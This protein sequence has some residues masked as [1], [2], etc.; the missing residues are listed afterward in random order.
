MSHETE[1]WQYGPFSDRAKHHAFDF[2]QERR[3]FPYAVPQINRRPVV[4]ETDSDEEEWRHGPFSEKA[5][6]HVF[7]RYPNAGANLYP[8]TQKRPLVEYC[9]NEWRDNGRDR[10]PSHEYDLPGDRID[11]FWTFCYYCV[12]SRKIRRWT[13]FSMIILASALYIHI[14]II[15]PII[16]ENAL[17][18]KSL[19]LR[20]QLAKGKILGGV[21]GTN[22]RPFFQDMV[23][24]DQLDQNHLP[25]PRASRHSNPA[26]GQR[27]IFV[28]DIHGCNKELKALMEKLHFDPAKD[29]L[30]TTGDMIA[31]GPHSLDVVDYLRSINAS[32]VRGNHEDWIL[33]LAHD[34]NSTLLHETGSGRHVAAEEDKTDK[35]SVAEDIARSLSAEQIQYLEACPVILRIGRVAAFDSEVVVVHAGLVPGLPLESQEPSS[36]MN[37]RTIDLHSHVPSKD[38]KEGPGSDGNKS[39]NKNPLLLKTWPYNVHWTKLWNRWQKTDGRVVRG[40]EIVDLGLGHMTV[41]Y[42][43]DSRRGVE[44]ENWTQGIDGAC[45]SGGKLTALVV[46]EGAVSYT[47]QV[48]CEDYRPR[49][50]MELEEVLREEGGV[51]QGRVEWGD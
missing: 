4:Q 30:V 33:L 47:E 24:I 39:P 5:E 6:H 36:V 48:R 10:S 9:T 27:L 29:H 40:K 38:G 34:M 35:E 22:T 2:Y 46:G 41:V 42:G 18:T 13:L 25:D 15:S 8:P 37:M 17:L 26:D 50:R 7:D 3:I 43:H 16:V 14:N 23:Y 20:E 49:K 32:C 12:T 21:F 45:V 31:K 11:Q 51:G 28:G 44:L 19:Q 1:D